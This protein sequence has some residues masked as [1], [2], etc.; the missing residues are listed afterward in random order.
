VVRLLF[1]D[2]EDST[3]LLH[4]LGNGYGEAPPSLVS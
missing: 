4:E 3:R 1:T 2:V